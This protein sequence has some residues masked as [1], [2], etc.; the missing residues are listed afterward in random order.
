VACC[1]GDDEGDGDGEGDGDVPEEP[2]GNGEADDVMDVPAAPGGVDEDVPDVRDEADG[3]VPAAE[4]DEP[5]GDGWPDV[6]GGLVLAGDGSAADVDVAGADAAE[7]AEP[8][9]AGVPGGAV[10]LHSA[11]GDGAVGLGEGVADAEVLAEGEGDGVAVPHGDIA[12][13][14]LA[15]AESLAVRDDVAAAGEFTEAARAVPVMP[16]RTARTPVSRLDV[17]SRGR[18]YRLAASLP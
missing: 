2:C 15:G 1:V 8:D 7:L 11:A 13:D 6:S 4:L 14:G 12:P 9:G 16:A 10:V 3:D 17:I 5:P 18:A